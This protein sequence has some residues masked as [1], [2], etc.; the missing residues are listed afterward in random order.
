MERFLPYK[1]NQIRDLTNSPFCQAHLQT[2]KSLKVR[3]INA[4]VIRTDVYVIFMP[5]LTAT[6]HR[7]AS[8]ALI[9][10]YAHGCR[11]SSGTVPQY[12]APLMPAL[13]QGGR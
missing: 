5:D 13:R 2:S 7:S 3:V 12:L 1:I 11:S 4:E 9:T 8:V 10:Y 6:R